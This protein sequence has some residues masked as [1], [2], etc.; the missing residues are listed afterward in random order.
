MRG[1]RTLPTHFVFISHPHVDSSVPSKDDNFLLADNSNINIYQGCQNNGYMRFV[2][3]GETG[4]ASY[5]VPFTMLEVGGHLEDVTFTQFG[6]TFSGN[7]ITMYVNGL[8]L[9]SD[10]LAPGPAAVA[11]GSVA[12]PAWSNSA[13][14][15]GQ[16]DLMNLNS[17][18][19]IGRF[20]L[21]Q[22]IFVGGRADQNEDRFYTGAI[23]GL[24]IFTDGASAADFQCI[25]NHQE[26]MILGTTAHTCTFHSEGYRWIDPTTD[27]NAERL[28]EVCGDNGQCT[29]SSG[30]TG[31]MRG[32]SAD[33][34][35]FYMDLSPLGISFPFMGRAEHE[36]YISANGYISFSGDQTGDS[37]QASNPETTV[38][39]SAGSKPDD[40]IFAYWTDLDFSKGGDVYI[41][42]GT[43]PEDGTTI[44]WLDAPYYCHGEG[45]GEWSSD[46][47][48]GPSWHT[49]TNCI[50]KTASFQVRDANHRH[51]SVCRPCSTVNIL[52]HAFILN[53]LSRHSR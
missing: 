30:A 1:Q 28:S 24:Q 14:T 43:A 4:F 27:P 41:S 46:P 11:M 40:A 20:R 16:V 52:T 8:Q 38:I 15:N 22:Y 26:Q 10:Q 42:T 44:T 35:Y 50:G 9:M 31:Q 29:F 17:G 19:G 32:P 3:V 49:G 25:Y 2:F 53:D 47:D 33:D 6:F 7:S 12:G 34:G 48:Y 37:G 23:A 5:D 36:L 13:V 45:D 39:P 21:D 51:C 18:A